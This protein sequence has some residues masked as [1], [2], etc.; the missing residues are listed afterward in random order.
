MPK[1][2]AKKTPA[3]KNAAKKTAGRADFI[4]RLS[5]NMLLALVLLFGIFLLYSNLTGSCEH[6]IDEHARGNCAQ[7]Q[8]MVLLF[9]PLIIWLLAGTLGTLR[10]ILFIVFRKT[11]DLRTQKRE[12][13]APF[14][15]PFVCIMLIAIGNIP[16]FIYGR[17]PWATHPLEWL[18]DLAIYAAW[19]GIFACFAYCVAAIVRGIRARYF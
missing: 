6:I 5:F 15:A 13:I 2:P 10:G 12:L 7:G 17:D 8:V 14:I 18:V 19:F 4:F 9:G 16:S 11:L 3:K 1:V